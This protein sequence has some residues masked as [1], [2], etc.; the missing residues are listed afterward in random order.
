MASL[1]NHGV[2]FAFSLSLTPDLIHEQILLPL[3]SEISRIHLLSSASLHITLSKLPSS[4]TNYCSGLLTAPSASALSPHSLF[5]TLLPLIL[6]KCKSHHIPSTAQS[7]KPSRGFSSYSES[8]SHLSLMA[9]KALMIWLPI[10][11][12]TSSMIAL[13]ARSIP[14]TLASS[15]PSNTP[16]MFPLQDVSSWASFFLEW[17]S[18]SYV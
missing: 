17:S 13:L 11:S 7:S 15:L 4:C 1:K 14:S 6:V 2:I 18:L 12:L 9:Y 10:I 8:Q 3:L 5:S 16:D